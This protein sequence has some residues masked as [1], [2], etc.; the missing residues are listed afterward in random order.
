MDCVVLMLVPIFGCLTFYQIRNLDFDYLEYI[1]FVFETHVEISAVQITKYA[2]LRFL[3]GPNIE[4]IRVSIL[5]K[6]I[7]DSMADCGI[8]TQRQILCKSIHIQDFPK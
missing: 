7:S 8:Y 4:R 2:R 6:A 1:H 3:R 5:V